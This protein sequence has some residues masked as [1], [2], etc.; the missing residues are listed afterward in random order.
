MKKKKTKK[1]KRQRAK[2]N[3]RKKKKKWKKKWKG[4]RKLKADSIVFG[5]FCS[6]FIWNSQVLM[7]ALG[8]KILGVL[9]WLKKFYL[10]RI[11]DTSY[12]YLIYIVFEFELIKFFISKRGEKIAS[13]SACLAFNLYLFFKIL[14]SKQR[15]R[16]YTLLNISCQWI[17]LHSYLITVTANLASV[18]ATLTF[19]I[20]C[21][22][23]LH[24]HRSQE[25]YFDS[26][27]KKNLRNRR[28]YLE[29]EQ[30]KYETG[31]QEEVGLPGLWFDIACPSLH[32]SPINLRYNLHI[33][34]E[35]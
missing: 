35:N 20:K 7:F 19:G 31:K 6:V 2:K 3:V 18:F 13:L 33:P 30:R 17:L 24:F 9:I 23:C 22:N 26:K 29:K 28:R 25:V 4:G 5:E 10:L 11:Q 12:W 32:R 34:D 8:I 14:W 21:L 16:F 1:N 15:L 27:K